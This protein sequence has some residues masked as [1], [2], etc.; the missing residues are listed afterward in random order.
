MFLFHYK[1]ILTSLMKK[2]CLSNNFAEIIFADKTYKTDL[3]MNDVQSHQHA[4]A[5]TIKQKWGV[6]SHTP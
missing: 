1:D 6:V 2:K 5:L 3:V 4:M